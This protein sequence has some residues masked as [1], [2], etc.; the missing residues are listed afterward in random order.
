MR[1][2]INTNGLLYFFSSELERAMLLKKTITTTWM[3]NEKKSIANKKSP[4]LLTAVL[5]KRA[6]KRDGAGEHK[7]KEKKGKG[8]QQY[9]LHDWENFHVEKKEKA[10][11]SI[12]Q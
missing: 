5:Q 4:T 12:W 10:K 8:M 3:K 6:C 1:M 9:M 7:E 11:K 2:D